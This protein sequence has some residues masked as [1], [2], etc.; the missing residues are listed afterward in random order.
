MRIQ[1][2]E[3]LIRDLRSKVLEYQAAG[4]N[5]NAAVKRAAEELGLT[6]DSAYQ[7]NMRL[8]NADY[9]P[10]PASRYPVYENPIELTGDALVLGDMHIPYHDAPFVNRC[11]LTA[12]DAGIKK[13]ILGGDWLDLHGMSKWP[14]DFAQT[15]KIISDPVYDKLAKFADTLPE[16]H[17]RE[18][19]EQ[20]ADTHADGELT[21]EM[22]AAREVLKALI[23]NFDEI[24]LMMGNHEN[25]LIRK[26]EKSLTGA[27]LSAL[28][29]S[30]SPKA[31]ITPFY[32]LRLNSGGQ[33]WQ[34]EH[35]SLAGKGSSG[36]KLAPKFGCNVIM[37]HNHHFSVRSDISGRFVGIE[38]GMC[39]DEARADY[40]MTR[41]NGADRH[42][43]GAVIIK[44]GKFQLLNKWTL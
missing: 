28:F 17:R 42:V 27:D 33:V 35:P 4:A 23:A 14:D 18:L 5:E 19:L 7:K 39:M 13:V 6:Y 11:I 10:L 9:T 37:L 3:K 25:R 34:V 40:V 31:K 2:N 36:A 41:H 32:W 24:V 20:L 21:S 8:K 15:P 29:L 26:L 22:A 1:W 30:N 38:P 43:T 12:Q 44:E 16:G